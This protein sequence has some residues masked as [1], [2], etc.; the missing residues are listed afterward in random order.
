MKYETKP[1]SVTL[2]KDLLT[3]FQ[4]KYPRLFT[5]FVRRCI[6]QATKNQKFFDDVFF[7]TVD[8]YSN[9]GMYHPEYMN[10]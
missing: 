8:D 5:V 7:G 6:I 4:S 10:G 9:L 2:P 3:D 1:M